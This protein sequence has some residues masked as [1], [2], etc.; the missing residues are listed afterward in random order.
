[1]ISGLLETDCAGTARPA[2]PED[3]CAGLGTGSDRSGSG[4]EGNEDFVED[5]GCTEGTGGDGISSDRGASIDKDLDGDGSSGGDGS[6]V[7]V[8]LDGEGASSKDSWL[9]NVGGSGSKGSRTSDR[10]SF[11]KGV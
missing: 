11:S 2:L 9:S 3:L 7:E 6:G 1:M 10:E 5:F 8:S 4:R